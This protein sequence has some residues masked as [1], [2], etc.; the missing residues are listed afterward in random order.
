MSSYKGLDLFGSGPHRFARGVREHLVVSGFALGTGGAESYALGLKDWEVLVVGRLVAAS[1]SALRTLRD[2][3]VDELEP[4]GSITP[5]TLADGLGQTWSDMV[6]VAFEEAD[7]VDR[8][9][10]W[11][12]GYTATF[13]SFQASQFQTFQSGS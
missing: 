4:L 8:G 5:G 9:R 2:A 10:A 7:R 13:R 3:V 1:E 12:V 11:S 6:L